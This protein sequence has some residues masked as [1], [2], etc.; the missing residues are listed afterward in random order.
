MSIV[1]ED[2]SGNLHGFS[3]KEISGY[4][5]KGFAFACEAAGEPIT[6][7]DDMD[8]LDTLQKNHENLQVKLLKSCRGSDKLEVW[9]SV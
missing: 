5:R 8:V 4:L 9:K 7:I 3:R 6:I 1:L 2:R